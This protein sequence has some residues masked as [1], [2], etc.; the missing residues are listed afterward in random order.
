MTGRT[1]RALARTIS[2][3]AL[4]AGLAPQA[5]AKPAKPDFID[6]EVLV[7]PHGETDDLLTAGLGW[8]GIA[9]QPPALDAAPNVEQLRRRA[10]HANM[11]GLISVLPAQGYGTLYGSGPRIPGVEYL[12]YLRGGPSGPAATLMVQ[13]PQGFDRANP[14]I[15]T[16]PSSGSRGIYGAISVAEVPLK[17]GCAVAYTDK[18]TGI[19]Y[20]D[21]ATGTAYD[22]EGRPIPADGP[23]QFRAPAGPAL[24]AFNAGHPNR[25][26]V[27]HAHRGDNPERDWG[28]HVLR[29]IEFALY[30]LNDHFD[31]Q[32]GI[33][34]F[35]PGNVTVVAVGVSNGGGAALLAAEADRTGLIDGIVVSEPQIQPAPRTDLTILERGEPQVHGRGLYEVFAAMNLYAD[36]ASG[37]AAPN[38]LRCAALKERRLLT[39]ETPPEQNVEAKGIIHRLGLLPDADPL[40]AWHSG[41]AHLWRVL[42]PTYAY[43]YAKASAA[44]HLCRTSFGAAGPEGVTPWSEAARAGAFATGNGLAG[45]AGLTV[46]ND[47]GG[48]TTN[49]L[50]PAAS[51]EGEL[52]RVDAA[53]CLR[54][55]MGQEALRAGLAEVR[56]TGDLRGRPALILHG[57]KDGL[58]APN[59]S[60]R[61]YLGLNRLVEGQRSGVRYVEVVNGNHFDAVAGA[62]GF[63][64]LVALHGYVN[65]GIAAMLDHLG[66]GKAPLPESQVFAATAVTCPIPV[67][68]AAA[69]RITW[70]DTTLAIPAG[71]PPACP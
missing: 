49:D 60:S 13:I 34:T 23:A 22:I 50:A 67:Q 41:T 3:L 10:I 59:H 37:T 12:A 5:E 65:Q 51:I 31:G 30:A 21:L 24:D 11:R 64:P 15:V 47:A 48:Q 57:R 66:K 16:A 45:S 40:M 44:D 36:C 14:C 26:A 1:R 39:A 63:P 4:V 42:T 53:I 25:V 33:G 19:G 54:D 55:L 52:R 9:G 6:G 32:P 27:K 61:A 56:A 8:E 29:S 70:E 35:N 18:G 38:V 68:P 71:S 58:V 43:A 46:L 17:R 28:Q 69:D 7:R 20:H 62:P 2:A